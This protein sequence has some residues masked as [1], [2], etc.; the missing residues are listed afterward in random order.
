MFKRVL[1]GCLA[2][3]YLVCACGA[4]A[5]ATDQ[6]EKDAGKFGKVFALTVGTATTSGAVHEMNIGDSIDLGKLYN[7]A[8]LDL[9]ER[10]ISPTGAITVYPSRKA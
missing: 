2:A 6:L 5:R 3:G 4:Q 7:A 1:C 9:M 8:P 10:L